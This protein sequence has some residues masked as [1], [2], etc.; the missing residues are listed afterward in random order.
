MISVHQYKNMCSRVSL[1]C[2]HVKV[3]AR[4]QKA[5]KIKWLAKKYGQKNINKGPNLPEELIDFKECKLFS[6][7]FTMTKEDGEGVEVVLPKM[8][9]NYMPEAQVI[10]Y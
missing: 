1:H 8:R 6:P 10:V 3:R 9:E 5:D 4:K 2:A 7:E